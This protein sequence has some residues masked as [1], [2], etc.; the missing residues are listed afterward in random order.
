MPKSSIML[1]FEPAC[2]F[3]H[4][5]DGAHPIIVDSVI[6]DLAIVEVSKCHEK[7]ADDSVCLTEDL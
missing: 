6:K 7:I 3:G 5:A 2:I 4:S 1:V